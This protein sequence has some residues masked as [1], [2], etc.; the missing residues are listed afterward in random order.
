MME[1]NEEGEGLFFGVGTGRCGTMTLVNLLNSE[2]DVTALHEGKF[3]H[4]ETAGQQLLPFLTLQNFHAYCHPSEAGKIIADRRGDMPSLRK[5]RGVRLYGDVAYNYAPF[6]ASLADLF[7][8]AYIIHIFRDGRDF[9]RS[10]YTAEIPDPTPVGWLDPN[11]PI[12]KLERY[13][14]L[15]RL[16]PCEDDPLAAD[17][18]RMTPVARNAWLWA[19]TN[20]IILDGLE[21]WPSDKI[22][23]I[24]FEDFF[25][26]P[27]ISYLQLRQRMGLTKQFHSSQI[28]HLL[29]RNI[30]ARL[31][32][33]LPRWSE[34]KKDVNEDFN[35]Y[36]GDMMYRLG[37]I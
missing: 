6:V 2:A 23:Q 17:W 37:Y 12:S 36:A 7:P 34:W 15:G 29:S 27:K 10:A 25:K 13:I 5:Q 1:P 32:T 28:D 16:R 14:A 4:G 20:R 22:I 18:N 35:R 19:E 31:Q 21:R 9:V 33:V 3:R 24:R 8:A 11:R 26:D 30:N